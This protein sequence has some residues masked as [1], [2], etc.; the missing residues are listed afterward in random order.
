MPYKIIISEEFEKEFQ[1]LPKHLQERVIK[2]REKIKENPYV[3]DP[4]G[5][6]FFRE[7]KLEGLRL[8]YLVYDDILVV[9]FVLLS[10]KKTQQETIDEIKLHFTDYYHQVHQQLKKS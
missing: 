2:L 7:K 8:Y 3:G 5:F 1:E 10:D 6:K 4:L 9:L